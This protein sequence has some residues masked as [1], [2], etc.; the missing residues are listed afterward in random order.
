[1]IDRKTESAIK[2]IKGFIEFWTKFHALY[3][4]TIQKTVVSAEDDRKFIEARDAIRKKYAQLKGAL[5]HNYMPQARF[6]DPVSDVLAVET[7]RFGSETSLK[8]LE[9]DWKDSYVFL[10]NIAERLR[11][12]RR[13]L[14]DF[15]PVGVFFKKMWEN[16]GPRDK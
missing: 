3:A 13:R 16:V 2:Q 12:K 10:N 5:D 1:M 7:V 15:N 4:E 6:T 9:N 14:E 8:K 11:Q